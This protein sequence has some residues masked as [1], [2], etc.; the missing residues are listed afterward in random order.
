MVAKYSLDE[1]NPSEVE[2]GVWC[3]DNDGDVEGATTAAGLWGNGLD[4]DGT[5]DY[6]EVADDSALDLT[7]QCDFNQCLG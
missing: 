4:F 2:D 5:N 1:T 3:H 6:V 7:D